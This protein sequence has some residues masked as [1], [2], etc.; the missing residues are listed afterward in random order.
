MPAKTLL[1]GGLQRRHLQAIARIRD[2]IDP[3]D[4]YNGYCWDV[5]ELAA[6]YLL[7]QGVECEFC[8]GAG[9]VRDPGHAY[10]ILTDGSIIDPTLDQFYAGGRG[11]YTGDWAS[12]AASEYDREEYGIEGLPRENPWFGQV[13]VIPPEHPFAQHYWSHRNPALAGGEAGQE[14]WAKKPGWY[15]KLHGLE[16]PEVDDL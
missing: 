3:R 15:L 5:A 6:R 14:Y 8:E 7:E 10:V 9:A 12:E 16:P 11:N 2:R 1:P 4:A 13:A